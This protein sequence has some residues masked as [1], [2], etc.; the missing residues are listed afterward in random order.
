MLQIRGPPFT[1]KT[2]SFFVSIHGKQSLKREDG[3]LLLIEILTNRGPYFSIVFDFSRNLL[4]RAKSGIDFVS[5][6]TFP[7]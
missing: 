1:F 7:T 4:F 3:A 2:P 6:K 5:I